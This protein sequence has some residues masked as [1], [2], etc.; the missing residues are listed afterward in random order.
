MHTVIQNTSK[1]NKINEAKPFNV[2]D[3]IS[4]HAQVNTP[5]ILFKQNF[6]HR[7]V[8]IYE[9]I[10]NLY[11]TSEKYYASMSYFGNYYYGNVAK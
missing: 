3:W 11:H 1:W 7:G 6:L 4:A 2:I 8:L 5:G 9:L 10:M